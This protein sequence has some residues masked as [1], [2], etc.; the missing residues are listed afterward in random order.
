VLEL[1]KQAREEFGIV[2]SVHRLNSVL[3][4]YVKRKEPVKA[5]HYLKEMEA[6]Q[7]VIPDTVSYTTL[8]QGYRDI[9]DLKTVWDLYE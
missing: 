6:V 3:L 1:E 4:A 5:H 2:P 8:I 7:K 9:N